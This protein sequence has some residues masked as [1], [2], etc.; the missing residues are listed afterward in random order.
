MSEYYREQ[1]KKTQLFGAGRGNFTAGGDS[2]RRSKG[3]KETGE[4]NSSRLGY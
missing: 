4:N 3:N 1:F 2:M